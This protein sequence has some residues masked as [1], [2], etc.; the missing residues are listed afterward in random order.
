[1]SRE[2]FS[3]IICRVLGVGFSAAGFIHLVANI[4]ESAWDFNPNYLGFFLLTQ[5]LRPSLW[6]LGG[7]VVY[8]LSRMLG[9]QISKW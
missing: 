1:M 2:E 3:V 5:C 9:R 4:V 8:A 6:I 7:V